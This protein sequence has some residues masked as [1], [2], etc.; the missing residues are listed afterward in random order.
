[1]QK[2]FKENKEDRK[3]KGTWHAFHLGVLLG[4]TYH[5]QMCAPAKVT[6]QLLGCQHVN[7]SVLCF[8]ACACLNQDANT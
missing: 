2:F 4:H 7:E 1:M 3:N 5:I 6:S 8:S